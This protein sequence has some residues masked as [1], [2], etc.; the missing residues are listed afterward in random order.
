MTN[1]VPSDNCHLNVMKLCN[2]FAPVSKKESFQPTDR[3]THCLGG[4]CWEMPVA[5]M[6]M[7]VFQPSLVMEMLV[8][9]KL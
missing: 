5:T 4:M 9:P 7:M 8:M 1:C 3:V 2:T 6:N